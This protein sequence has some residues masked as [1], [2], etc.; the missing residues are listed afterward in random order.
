MTKDDVSDFVAALNEPAVFVNETHVGFINQWCRLTFS[1]AIAGVADSNRARV[2]VVM[3]R[4]DA[5]R[6]AE[7]I[8]RTARDSQGTS[9]IIPFTGVPTQ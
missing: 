5:I 4:V 6:M 3:P 8:L 7:M 2:A 1:E 9:T